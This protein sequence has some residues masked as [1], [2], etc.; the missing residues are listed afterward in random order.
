[1]RISPVVNYS[2]NGQNKANGQ[3]FTGHF[4]ASAVESMCRFAKF[5]N[6]VCCF[7]SM[8]QHMT[9]EG[10]HV[11]L[12]QIPREEAKSVPM[13]IKGY[14]IWTEALENLKIVAKDDSGKEVSIGF[15]ANPL[16]SCR[17]IANDMFSSLE[18]IAK[19]HILP[20]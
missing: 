3:K 9:S 7:S 4:D 13:H 5:K 15:F 14:G 6:A 1:M 8:V 19:E 10:L 12:V 2:I 16:R 20:Q 11:S 18:T 17:K